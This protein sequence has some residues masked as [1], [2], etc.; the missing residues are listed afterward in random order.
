MNVTLRGQLDGIR[1]AHRRA[2]RRR[3]ALQGAA[4]WLAGLLVLAVIDASWSGVAAATGEDPFAIVES[5]WW[6]RII[7]ATGLAGR[8]V[9]VVWRSRVRLDVPDWRYARLCEQRLG[10]HDNPLVNAVQLQAR[11]DALS[12][13]LVARARRQADEL[14]QRIEATDVID[15]R[16]LR[17][18]R[19][20]FV[21]VLLAWAIV[22]GVSWG[23]TVFGPSPLSV[24][25]VRVT[26]PWVDQPPYAMVKLY[27][28]HGPT[29][30]A[31]GDDVHIG[32]RALSR[33]SLP[34]ARVRL[35]DGQVMPMIGVDSGFELTLPDV[36]EPMRY[37]VE[38]GGTRTR[39][40]R[41]DPLRLPRIEGVTARVHADQR[42]TPIG[43][44][45]TGPVRALAGATLEL[46]V[47]SNRDD[48]VIEGAN[49]DGL[50]LS[51]PI[52]PGR[53]RVA[54]GL[55]TP[56]GLTSREQVMF[57]LVG[58]TTSEMREVAGKTGEPA[59]GESMVSVPLVAEDAAASAATVSEDGALAELSSGE[60]AEGSVEARNG[61]A[62]SEVEPG[63]GVG[64][65]M[66][67]EG[68][69]QPPA[70]VAGDDAVGIM[71]ERMNVRPEMRAR[72]RAYADAAP[73]AYRELTA[74]YFL[75]LA[76]D[77]TR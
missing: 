13:E 14:A 54:F 34:G 52:Q 73:R 58:L 23:M 63:E 20:W 65:G 77:E 43:W 41:I 35:G 68:M 24:G 5:P 45:P 57:E 2:A 61:E 32:A 4:A 48:A 29:P 60:A 59:E 16:P 40:R 70:A 22:A 71:L 8:L 67:G 44:P 9:V 55:R 37:V 47:L 64:G 42:T 50:H 3:R 26:M 25:V 31:V 49:A 76:E 36:R 18:A 28:G 39:W 7:A 66:Q 1:A 10:L 46:R 53:K 19:R 51:V 15:T 33:R 75:R 38:A 6:L 56:D 72:I 27:A 74:Q 12:H 11:D 62:D 69:G 30:A 21:G 17:R